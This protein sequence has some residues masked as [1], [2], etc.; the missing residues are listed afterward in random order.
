MR[1]YNFDKMRDERTP[2]IKKGGDDGNGTTIAN[3]LAPQTEQEEITSPKPSTSSD[4]SSSTGVKAI[5]MVLILGTIG[6]AFLNVFSLIS[7]PVR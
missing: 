5:I 1:P 7:A 4:I 2:L 6:L 3:A